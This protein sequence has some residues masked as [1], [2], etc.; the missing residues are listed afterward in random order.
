MS[1]EELMRQKN[2]NNN[3]D[4]DTEIVEITNFI[5]TEASCSVKHT[6][7]IIDTSE[8]VNLPL[9]PYQKR[10]IHSMA[11]RNITPDDAKQK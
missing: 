11:I 8:D 1:T 7:I 3:D 6:R 10:L 9:A 2:E 4:D 5:I